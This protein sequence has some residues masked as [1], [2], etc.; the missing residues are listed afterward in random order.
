MSQLK[1][2]GFCAEEEASVIA[3]T[4]CETSSVVQDAVVTPLL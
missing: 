3:N 4:V 2:V 1:D